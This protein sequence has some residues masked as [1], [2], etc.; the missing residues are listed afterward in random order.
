MVMILRFLRRGY[1]NLLSKMEYPV[2]RKDFS[3]VDKFHGVEVSDVYRWLEDPNADETKIFIEN[4][5]KISRKF[6]EEGSD[7]DRIEKKLTRLWNYPKYSCPTKHGKYY[8][9]YVNTGLQN[10]NVLFQ[11]KQLVD[12]PKVFLDPNTWSEDGT[13][14]LSQKSFSEDGN[15]MAYGISENGSD[16]LKIKIRDVNTGEDLKETLEK[17]KFSEISWTIDNEGFFYAQ[18]D[19]YADGAEVKQNENQ[20]LYYHYVGKNQNEDVLIAEFPEE[21]SWRM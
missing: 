18:Y 16:W 9:F 3:Y 17:V 1:S 12:E 5:N 8:Y 2:A 19:Q 13:V 15:Y 21:P 11:Q 20:K 6:I 7:R 10:Q 14:A 4:Q